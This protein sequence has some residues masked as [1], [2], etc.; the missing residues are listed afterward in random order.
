MQAWEEYWTSNDSNTPVFS[1]GT[2]NSREEINLFWR[3]AVSCLPSNAAIGDIACGAGAVFDTIPDINRF[4]LVA[5]D[6]SSAA[7]K[8]LRQK[9]NAASILSNKDLSEVTSPAVDML[10]SQF[11]IEYLAE[12]E[13]GNAFSLLKKG[14]SFIALVHSKDG[15]IYGKYKTENRQLRFIHDNLLC[16]SIYRLFVKGING[17]A[18]VMK[19]F[20]QLWNNC[21]DTPDNFIGGAQALY[22]GSYQILSRCTNYQPNDVK[23]WLLGIEQQLKTATV[24]TQQIIDVAM[25]REQVIAMCMR[26]KINTDLEIEPL[27]IKSQTYPISWSVKGKKC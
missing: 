26:N 18:F 3:E 5:H 24:N 6:G 9:Y 12:E 20:N 15:Y 21:A 25:T 1:D 14:G 11:G 7:R 23:D 17:Y 4:T 22:N 13:Q 2:G 27:F 19:E 16:E 10:M 8:H